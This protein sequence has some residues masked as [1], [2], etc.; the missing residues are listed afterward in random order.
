MLGP[1]LSHRGCGLALVLSLLLHSI[2]GLFL[3]MQ[4][5]DRNSTDYRG[6]M[7]VETCL[8][9]S[10][11]VS[12]FQASAPPSEAPPPTRISP[13]TAEEPELFPAGPAPMLLQQNPSRLD[14]LVPAVAWEPRDHGSAPSIEERDSVVRT[15]HS[16][17]DDGGGVSFF[18]I[19][20]QG[21]A[22][23]YVI[24]RSA[25]MGLHGA[26]ETAKRE[27]LSSLEY[28]PATARFQVIAYN[29][30]AEPL[31][32][33]GRSE[34]VPA[35]RENKSAVTAQLLAIRAEGSTEHLRALQRALALQPDI[36]FF[37]TDA[38]DL[39]SEQV[40]ALTT[41]NHGRCVIHALQ[42]AATPGS[43]EESHR[44]LAQNNRGVYRRVG[45]TGQP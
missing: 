17:D 32:V 21:Q 30:Q 40:Q 6:R 22:I 24:D 38:D 33:G 2:G 19:R 10:E 1:S 27:L 3:W 36:I 16:G 8:L 37:L 14:A 12:R 13:P 5:L 39:R 15:G 18:G 25:S 31:R 23:V 11:S 4:S 41:Q 7:E 45:V 29:R 44:R 34:L 9:V 35:S 42:L 28:L 43:S 20:A 26:L